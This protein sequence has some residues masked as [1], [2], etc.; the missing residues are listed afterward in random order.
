MDNGWGEECRVY[1]DVLSKSKGYFLRCV[2]T[3]GHN[4]VY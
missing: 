1:D 4:T 3:E 2:K